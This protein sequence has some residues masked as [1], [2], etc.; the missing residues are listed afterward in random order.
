[1]WRRHG[2]LAYGSLVLVVFCVEV[3]GL[4]FLTLTFAGRLFSILPYAGVVGA[5]VGVVVA[6][7]AALLA[8]T[9]YI[10]VYHAMTRSHEQKRALRVEE[11]T[12]QWVRVLYGEATLPPLTEE[13]TEA[14]LNL[15]HLLTGEEGRSIADGL[16]RS[17]AVAALL[18][19]L[20]SSRMV[21]RMEALDALAKARI[22]TA[23]SPIVRMMSSSEPVVRLMAARAAARTLSEWFG[24]G[25]PEAIAAFAHAL[26]R[27]DLPA[28]AMAETLLLL[29][30]SA[31]GVVARL[32]S[33]DDLPPLVLRASLDAV[34]RL[35][36]VEFAYEAAVW[37]GH[38]DP[39]V[40]AAAFRALGRLGR[41][42]MRA[43]DA[44]A[45]ALADD[46]EFVRVQAARAA[47]FVPA[48]IAV[49]ALYGSL[50]DRSWW[51]RRAAA[52]SLLNRGR[53]GIATLKDAARAHHD[54][55]A[56]DMAA[57]VLLDGGIVRIADLPGLKASA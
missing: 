35:H 25:L 24:P 53:W 8:L 21:D 34:G 47:A 32:L 1:M 30:G 15:R 50:G 29:E 13:A 46:T 56:R 52:E 31:P 22:P 45:I 49:R 10:L 38:Q 27:A 4:G 20:R 19:K 28:G 26:R 14:G 17:G 41:M 55:F 6:T 43:R 42:P 12:D 40:R 39:E 7:A 18:R 33:D 5:L 57:Q 44:V 36:M 48:R 16:W 54:R 37:I 3:A 51:V 9:G 23:L 11:W 2:D